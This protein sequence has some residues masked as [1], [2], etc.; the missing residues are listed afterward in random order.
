MKKLLLISSL[1]F[2]QI[3]CMKDYRRDMIIKQKKELYSAQSKISE[4][5][6]AFVK[7]DIILKSEQ[8]IK[9]AENA[10]AK[11]RVSQEKREQL[12]NAIENLKYSKK[13]LETR[14]ENAKEDL[15]ISQNPNNGLKLLGSI[16]IVTKHQKV[17]NKIIEIL[18]KISENI[19][20]ILA[21]NKNKKFLENSEMLNF[22]KLVPKCK[23]L[24]KALSPSKKEN[25][26]EVNL[27]SWISQIEQFRVL[28]NNRD[29]EIAEE[30]RVQIK[31]IIAEGEIA[32]KEKNSVKLEELKEKKALPIL[33][34][35][36]SNFVNKGNL[37]KDSEKLVLVELGKNL[38]KPEALI[39]AKTASIADE[40]EKLQNLISRANLQNSDEWKQIED[41]YDFVLEIKRKIVCFED[42]SEFNENF[43]KTFD[44]PLDILFNP[45]I[46]RIDELENIKLQ[47]QLL[48]S[49]NYLK[50]KLIDMAKKIK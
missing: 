11:K 33:E 28:S 23:M 25:E 8:L 13:A 30:D 9:L 32:I 41:K 4:M 22:Q 40:Y 21:T 38:L 2:T 50:I 44:L 18:N 29:I 45:I 39:I 42:A 1:L 24:I 34:K 17:Q 43:K 12:E 46:N 37:I 14:L 49:I 5:I 3:S 19:E 10:I 31:D 47:K 35:I 16:Y 7:T 6:T 15:E 36:F 48:K 27:T 20:I 26:E